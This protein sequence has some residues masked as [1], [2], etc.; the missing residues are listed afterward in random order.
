MM[1]D[2][3]KGAREVLVQTEG[4]GGGGLRKA[5]ITANNGGASNTPQKGIMM[6]STMGPRNAAHQGTLVVRCSI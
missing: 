4:A 2:T 3:K 5:K 6:P 1:G